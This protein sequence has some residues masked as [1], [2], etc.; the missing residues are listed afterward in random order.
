MRQ[1]FEDLMLSLS[2]AGE[3]GE[4]EQIVPLVDGQDSSQTQQLKTGDVVP[5]LPLRKMIL[6][7]GVLLPV[8][9]SRPKSMRLVEKAYKD[10]L[11]IGVFSQKN[12]EIQDPQ[13][14]DIYP[15]GT[16]AR[17]LRIFDVPDGSMMA[18]LEG[19]QRIWMNEFTSL[20]PQIMVRVDVTP[21]KMPS[22]RDKNF[23]AL[24]TTIKEQAV[25][26]LERATN[27]PQEAKMMLR[28]ITSPDILINY[29]CVNFNMS[30]EE[31]QKLILM[32][33][34]RVRGEMLL[35]FLVREVEMVKTQ[36]DIQEKAA[37]TMNK[38][39][40]E[41]FLHHQLEAIQ[42]ELGDTE[43][44]RFTALKE[45][46]AKKNWPEHAKT[47]FEDTMKKVERESHHSPD[48]QMDVTY[49]ETMLDLPW[50]ECTEDNYD[51]HQAKEVLDKDHYG[52][53]KVKER[54]IEYLA[55]LKLKGDMKSPILCLYGPPGVG[56]TSLG[57]SVARATGR[58]YVRVSL[59]GLHDE[60]EIRGHRRTYIG[61]MPGRI[62]DSIRRAG[63]TNPV[64]VLDEI[65][66][67]REDFHGDPASALLEVLDPEQNTTFHDNYLDIDYDLSKVLF[68]TTANDVSHIHPALLDRMELIN[69]TG[70]LPQE[71]HVI[72]TNY[73]IPKQREAHGLKEEQ[74]RF[75]DEAI[76]TIIDSYTHESGVR[77][78]DKQLAKVA[79]ITARKIAT[80]ENRSEV[81]SSEDIRQYLG[82]PTSFHDLQDGNEAVGVV[83]GLA[84]TQMGGEILFVECSVSDGK[85]TISTTGNLG[86]VM[87]E[88]ATIA[89]QYLKAHPDLLGVNPEIFQKKDIHI[90]VPEGAIPKDGPSAGITMVCAIASAL[91]G[92]KI[93]GGI[94]MT[95]ET[96]LRGKVLP[97]GGIKEKILAAK[98]AGAKTIVLSA[99]NERDIR[100]IKPIYVE[101]LE[102]KY[103]KTLD[104]VLSF[105]FSGDGS[106]D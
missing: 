9:L 10:E 106:A 69:V 105:V 30:I 15:I 11:I 78:L 22:K 51:I 21:E 96:T 38:E 5:V 18:I 28:G 37:E 91:K 71:K 41:Y 33:D 90:H 101:G 40:R 67:V 52:M 60:S 2:L 89:Y 87:K 19:T 86:D 72:A 8:T 29:I 20:T 94:A 98:R 1:D 79:R 53:E 56:K 49:L 97:V 64:L 82:L 47:A 63:V 44:E 75:S 76:D 80:D 61:A 65:D 16:A 59:G 57:K 36:A 81:L 104:E 6:F 92:V 35:E 42:K 84:W 32:D 12:T 17:V 34:M 48:Y 13:A 55:V 31:K 4:E 95:G 102:F 14:N 23:L 83:T 27:L 66:K 70:Y 7:P 74:F 26:I 39:Q 73:L 25:Y 3:N 99:E 45:R 100:E 62:I 50:N 93:R 54:I 88:S 58:K 85:G 24:A 77:S 43:D 46:A 68:I 103:V